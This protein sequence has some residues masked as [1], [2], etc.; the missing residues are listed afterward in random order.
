MVQRL[1]KDGFQVVCV[2]VC[3]RYHV[4]FSN[5]WYLRLAEHL[6]GMYVNRGGNCVSIPTVIAFDFFFSSYLLTTIASFSASVGVLQGF[7]AVK[8]GGIAKIT[9]GLVSTRLHYSDL[10]FI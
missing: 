7:G 10:S 4:K 5:V 9:K 8:K 1:L 6:L 3:D 2:C